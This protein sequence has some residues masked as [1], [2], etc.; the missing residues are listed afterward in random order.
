[1]H[2]MTVSLVTFSIKTLGIMTYLQHQN[3]YLG[4]ILTI[5]TIFKD[6]DHL[7][8]IYW[9]SNTQ[10]NGIQLNDTKDNGIIPL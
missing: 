10:Y 5:T 1:M 7:K 4:K 2:A 6:D 9:C 3:D 8:P